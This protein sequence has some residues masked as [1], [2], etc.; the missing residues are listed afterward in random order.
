MPAADVLIHAGDVSSMGKR[1]EIVSFLDWF[2]A[3]PFSY[4]IF[5]A[6]NH[7]FFFEKNSNA[8][9]FRLIPDNVIY[10]NDSGVTIEGI[11][12]WGSP[13]SPWF[14][15]WAFNR[16]RGVDIRSHWDMI[17]GST[18]ILITHGPPAGIL[19]RTTGG[20]QVGCDDLLQKIKEIKPSFHI[21]GHIHEGY[22][23]QKEDTT[24]YI[25]ASVVDEKYRITNNPVIFDLTKQ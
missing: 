4:K 16:Q 18:D 25:N 23:T 2:S 9:I 5:I 1:E 8:E 13:I 11:E 21:F 19:D 15:D 10:L 24:T 7:D 14:Y 3:L 17:P 6:G 22:G 20:Q 12:I